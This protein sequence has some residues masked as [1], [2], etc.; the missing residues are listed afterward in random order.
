MAGN[1]LPAGWTKR[2]GRLVGG[3]RFADF[4]RAMKFV[5]AVA[6]RAEQVEHHPDVLVHWNEVRFEVWSHDEG[7]V[8]TRDHALV[9]DI[10]KIARRQKGRSLARR[11]PAPRGL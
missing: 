4:V 2:K 10:A 1:G 8:T 6:D 9:A 7:K 5:N 3:Y 11:Q